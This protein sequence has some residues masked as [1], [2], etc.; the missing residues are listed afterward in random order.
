MDHTAVAG[1]KVRYLSSEKNEAYYQV[2]PNM[3]VRTQDLE[4][5]AF[6]CMTSKNITRAAESD[7]IKQ[8]SPIEV[9]G[10]KI[11]KSLM[12]VTFKKNKRILERPNHEHGRCSPGTWTRKILD[13]I[14]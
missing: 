8:N 2:S 9:T 5:L 10:F 4:S 14:G 1:A 6:D 3:G 7:L 13:G 11:D 12:T